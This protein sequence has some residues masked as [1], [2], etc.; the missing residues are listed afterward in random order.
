LKENPSEAKH[1]WH[2]V[3]RGGVDYEENAPA[4]VLD[5]EALKVIRLG[6]GNLFT[7]TAR[8]RKISSYSPSNPNRKFSASPRATYSPKCCRR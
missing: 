6:P 8:Y 1:F 4:T 5:S 2:D 7:I 3:S